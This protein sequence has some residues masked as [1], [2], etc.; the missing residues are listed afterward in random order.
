LRRRAYT[1]KHGDR[2]TEQRD[3]LVLFQLIELHSIPT[4]RDR[5][6]HIE[7]AGIGQRVV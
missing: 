4:S 5:T 7:L 1:N 2:A 6:Q 3:E